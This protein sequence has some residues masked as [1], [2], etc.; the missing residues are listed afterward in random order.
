[1]LRYYYTDAAYYRE[2]LLPPYP[3]PN[4]KA[5]NRICFAFENE[6]FLFPG[7][8]HST[9]FILLTL[10][11]GHTTIEC[12]TALWDTAW[13]SEPIRRYSVTVDDVRRLNPDTWSIPQFRASRD[14][15][16]AAKVYASTPLLGSDSTFR[17][18]ISARSN[19]RQG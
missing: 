2:D 14:A 6:R 19:A 7:A 12:A 9:R 17:K 10:A 1:M 13:L 5:A 16:I 8:H 4:T 3:R 15:E 11:P 18:D